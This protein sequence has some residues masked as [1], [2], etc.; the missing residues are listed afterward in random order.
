MTSIGETPIHHLGDLIQHAT[1]PGERRMGR[2]AVFR[3]MADARWPL[4][5]SLD[6]HMAGTVDPPGGFTIEEALFHEFKAQAR[7]HLPL[8]VENDWEWL[9]VAQHHGLPT[10]LLDWTY[11]PLVAAHFAT[12][13]GEPDAERVVWE[14]DWKRLQRLMASD[15]QDEPAVGPMPEEHPW[16]AGTLQSR[17][18]DE[19]RRDMWGVFD[20][21]REGVADAFVLLF[22]PPAIVDRVH[23]Q[24]GT[25]TLASRTGVPFEEILRDEGLES[26]LHRYVIPARAVARIREELDA[27]GIDE[28]RLFPDL[29]GIAK[30]LARQVRPDSR[31]WQAIVR[32][33]QSKARA[34]RMRGQ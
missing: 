26:V 30:G 23:T 15:G 4:V 9:A 33:P 25:F 8:T 27:C 2:G 18:C 6:R 21:R 22:D 12:M 28:R 13:G 17:F 32:S 10:R 20:A 31:T 14:L 29:D 24:A 7:P 16:R 19:E 11:S 3:G 5:T 1:S 34:V